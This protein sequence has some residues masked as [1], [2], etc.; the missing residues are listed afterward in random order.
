VGD[1]RLRL[2]DGQPDSNT[3]TARANTQRGPITQQ[4]RAPGADAPVLVSEAVM[5]K[6]AAPVRRMPQAGEP[7]FTVDLKIS[8]AGGYSGAKLKAEHMAEQLSRLGR[9]TNTRLVFEDQG[10]LAPGAKLQTRLTI[11][12]GAF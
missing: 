6:P 12:A 10:P 2:T 3:K 7:T 5:F 11:A 1:Q 9:L 8:L 4:A